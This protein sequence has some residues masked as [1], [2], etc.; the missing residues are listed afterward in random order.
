MQ[1]TARAIAAA[2]EAGK[3][4]ATEKQVTDQEA[5]ELELVKS[6]C[7]SNADKF[8][9]ARGGEPVRGWLVVSPGQ[10]LTHSIVRLEGVLY[11]VTPI[12]E[13][14]YKFIA[15]SDVPDGFWSSDREWSRVTLLPD[16]DPA[17]LL[18]G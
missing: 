4:V 7:H 14:P 5:R 15:A 16:V 11:E 9:E 3:A 12:S 13:G 1:H 8:V 2:V 18:G 10:Y 17:L 6:Q